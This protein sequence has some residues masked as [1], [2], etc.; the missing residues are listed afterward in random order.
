VKADRVL[1]NGDTVTLGDVAM[2]ALLTPGHTKGGT[3]W[4]MNVVEGGKVYHVVF[5]D[6][7]SINPGYRLAKNPSYPGIADDYCR[8]FHVLEMLKPDIWLPSHTSFFDFAGR[9]ARVAQDGIKA[10]VDPE[11]YRKFVV[12]RKH[13]FESWIDT[14]DVGA[15]IRRHLV[16][17]GPRQGQGRCDPRARGPVEVHRSV[18]SRRPPLG[19]H[20]LQSR[21]RTLRL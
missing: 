8:T 15:R 17:A 4:T 5:P 21:P 12:G 9:R 16:A 19:P 3:T 10:W 18:R 11:G 2:T 6:G 1:R 7:Y 20:R 13:T 14:R